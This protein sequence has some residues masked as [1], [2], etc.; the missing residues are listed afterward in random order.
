MFTPLKSDGQRLGVLR[1]YMGRHYRFESFDVSL[2]EGIASQV[3]AVISNARLRKDAAEGEKLD[4]QIRLAG[5]V[6]RRMIPSHPPD[7][8]H[9]E[10]GCVYEPSAKLSG[11]FYDFISLP[12]GEMG[13]VI[14]DVVGKGVPA[15]LMMASTRSALRSF[16]ERVPDIGELMR[17]VN[18]RLCHDTLPSEFVTAFYLALGTSGKSIRFCNAGHE[19]LLLLRHGAVTTLDVGGLVLGLDEEAA[20]ECGEVAI[21]PGDLLLLVTD[22]LTEAMDYRGNVYGRDRLQSS[23]KL[24]GALAPDMPVDLVAK[25]V[26]WDVRRFAGLAP[27]TDDMT[28]VAIRAV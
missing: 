13:V 19:P 17:R 4:R 21:E 16:A 28:V 25:Q 12:S 2:M 6:Q 8:S 27:Q 18:L 15:S 3:S 26:L 7:H 10:F 24:H 22:G 1:A 5:E 20:Y 14:A 23:I 11:D 9:Y